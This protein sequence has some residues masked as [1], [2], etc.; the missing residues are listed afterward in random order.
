MQYLIKPILITLTILFLQGCST[1]LNE[2]QNDQKS[3]V[4]LYQAD[5]DK[6]TKTQ[7]KALGVSSAYVRDSQNELENRFPML[8]NPTLNMF[9]Y[10]HLIND[11]HPVPGY[12]TNF[13]LYEVDQYAL[14]S[15]MY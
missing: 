10:P 6:Q 13:K 12:T 4:D 11:S 14:P 7:Y 8:P 1:T 9:I 2:S 5:T 15:E 3:V